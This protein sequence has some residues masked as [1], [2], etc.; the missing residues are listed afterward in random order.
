MSRNISYDESSEWT[1]VH[2]I[3]ELEEEE[4]EP[5]NNENTNELNE[6]NF[7][8]IYPQP[9][10]V[11]TNN[12]TNSTS[13]LSNHSRNGSSGSSS[14]SSNNDN[15]ENQP[16]VPAPSIHIE[17]DP[18]S[19]NE[20][21]NENNED[22][23]RRVA[24]HTLRASLIN[25]DEILDLWAGNIP[26]IQRTRRTPVDRPYRL[27]TGILN[28]PPRLSRRQNIKQNKRRMLY[29]IEE[30]NK[31]K[32]FIKELCFSTDGRLICSPYGN[33]IRL[34]SFSKNCQELPDVLPLSEQQPQKLN[35]LLCAEQ[36][37]DI[38]V[39]LLLFKVE[40]RKFNVLSFQGFNKI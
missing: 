15:D 33:G 40:N 12:S 17:I 7:D 8:N 14:S 6:F 28:I 38:V 22:E 16:Q 20:P 19:D 4:I 32:G 24:S 25:T 18:P 34:L 9:R 1:C 30:A 27:N 3:Q 21:E 29:Y 26:F 5:E 37:T 36:H 11:R 31:G 35:Q 23:Q 39:S 13:S 10:P 2:D